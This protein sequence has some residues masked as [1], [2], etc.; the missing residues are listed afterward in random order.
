MNKSAKILVTAANG[1]TGFPTALM[2]ASSGCSR[3]EI[4]THLDIALRV[5]D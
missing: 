5:L 4:Q 3:R 2:L 1:N